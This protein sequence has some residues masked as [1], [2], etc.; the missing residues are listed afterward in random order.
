MRADK[1]RLSLR[2]AE[3]PSPLTVTIARLER[4]S[5]LPTCSK[6]SLKAS[7]GTISLD[8]T[9]A[10]RPGQAMDRLQLVREQMRSVQARLPDHLGLKL[11]NV[12]VYWSLV[13]FHLYNTVCAG[14]TEECWVAK[15]LR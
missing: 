12:V 11:A 14:D 3:R 15:Y 2:R 1:V 8:S 10:I 4:L 5:R 6:V 9:F 7:S 13:A